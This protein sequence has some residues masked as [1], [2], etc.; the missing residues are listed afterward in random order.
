VSEQSEQSIASPAGDGGDLVARA[1]RYYR[2]T[3]Y[4]LALGVLIYGIWNIHDGFFTWPN[5][6]EVNFQQGFD[7]PLHSDMDI[8]FN[9]VLGLGLVPGSILLLAWAL[10]NS[11]GEIRLSGQTLSVPGHPPVSL[12]GIESIDKS[13]WDRKGIAWV[14]YRTESLQAGKF[15]LDDFVYERDPID[16]IYK[17]IEQS[18]QQPVKKAMPTVAA[19]PRA[20]R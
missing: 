17:R 11:R 6:N 12:T 1:G 13:K 20:G 18:L 8:L 14:S 5:E 10:Y 2:N 3:R 7:K 9:R 15:K 16:E 19:V 4:L